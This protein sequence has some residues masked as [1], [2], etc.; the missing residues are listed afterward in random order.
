MPV[1]IPSELTLMSIIFNSFIFKG[2]KVILASKCIKQL[3][4]LSLKDS[5]PCWVCSNSELE[6][7]YEHL[8]QKVAVRQS[9][10]SGWPGSPSSQDHLHMAEMW[11][12]ALDAGQAVCTLA[13]RDGYFGPS[14]DLQSK[15]EM[16]GKSLHMELWGSHFGFYMV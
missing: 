8:G 6:T 14:K 4:S 10:D 9:V 7:S 12:K 13:S 11:E 3:Y 1:I 2:E 15:G 5:Y 16:M